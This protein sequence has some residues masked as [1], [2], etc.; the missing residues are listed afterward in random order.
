MII[1]SNCIL[2]KPHFI[3]AGKYINN[4]EIKLKNVITFSLF[5]TNCKRKMAKRAIQTFTVKTTQ[6]QKTSCG[7]AGEKVKVFVEPAI[8]LLV[9]ATQPL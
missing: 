4:T 7:T 6:Y 5:G 3:Q 2:K 8:R 9:T 1:G